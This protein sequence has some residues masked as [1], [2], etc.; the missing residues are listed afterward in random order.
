MWRN[1][2]YEQ[3]INESDIKLSSLS[4]LVRG[5][6]MQPCVDAGAETQKLFLCYVIELIKMPQYYS[7][8]Y[9]NTKAR[10]KYLIIFSFFFPPVQQCLHVALCLIT[11]SAC[12]SVR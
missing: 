10:E 8:K 6:N 9:Y 7:T 5:E 4:D 12:F 3:S 11:I 1:N 2:I